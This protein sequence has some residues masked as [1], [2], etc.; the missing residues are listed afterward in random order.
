[1]STVLTQT[2]DAVSE[3]AGTLRLNG[4]SAPKAAN[5]P[6]S[7]PQADYPYKH[8]LPSYDQSLKLPP[9]EPFEHVDPGHAAL[10][11]VN[12]RSFLQSAEV[13]NLTPKFGSEVKG[14]QLSRLDAHAKR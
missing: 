3:A 9:L 11:D 8:L 12:P 2:V 7:T 14:I 6:P 13:K 4:S 10:N 1:M 5:Q